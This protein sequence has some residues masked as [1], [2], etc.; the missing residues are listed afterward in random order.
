MKKPIAIA[1][2]IV[3][4]MLLATTQVSAESYYRWKDGNGQVHY[5]SRPPHGVEAEK[6]KTY[7]SSKPSNSRST[8]S[9]AESTESD[10]ESDLS[11][12]L[13]AKRA[14]DCKSAK[15]R[16]STLRSSSRIRM[17]QEDGSASKY[18]SPEEQA[19]EIAKSEDFINNACK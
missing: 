13:N 9:A 2:L 16:L 3:L 15:E 11:A 8:S 4:P 14:A 17:S 1:G 10:A 12:Q 7:G 18:L 6:I 19:K 5:G